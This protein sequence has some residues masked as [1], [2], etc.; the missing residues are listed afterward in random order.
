MNEI[1]WLPGTSAGSH[2]AA[3][4]EGVILY[5]YRALSGWVGG[6]RWATFDGSRSM[7]RAMCQGPDEAR[8]YAVELYREAVKAGTLAR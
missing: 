8:R 6:G 1:L 2:L 4:E 5:A 7:G 3:P